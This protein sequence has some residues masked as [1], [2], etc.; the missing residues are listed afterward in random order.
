MYFIIINYWFVILIYYFLE[1]I[2]GKIMAF[3][4]LLHRVV[5]I[6]SISGKIFFT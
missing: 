6:S 2:R 5:T 4:Q 1:V 3:M